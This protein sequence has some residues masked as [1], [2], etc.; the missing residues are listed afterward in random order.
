MKTPH[1]KIVAFLFFLR[2]ACV[3][4]YFFVTRI[5]NGIAA[6]GTQQRSKVTAVQVWKC[7]ITPQ[8]E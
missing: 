4:L 2:F 7:W 1:Y 3:L 6:H 8:K 5:C